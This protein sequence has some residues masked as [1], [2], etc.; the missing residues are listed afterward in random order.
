MP[1]HWNDKKIYETK[2]VKIILFWT[3]LLFFLMPSNLQWILLAS[4]SFV[5]IGDTSHLHNGDKSANVSILVQNLHE[6]P[7]EF[8][9]FYHKT[10][11]M[12]KNGPNVSIDSHVPHRFSKVSIYAEVC[13]NQKKAQKDI[14][15]KS[16]LW[17]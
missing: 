11:Q 7:N 1:I 14:L 17:G 13:T 9:V 6:S 12:R 15:H 3:F 16:A 8:G 5:I 10:P 2:K 4:Q